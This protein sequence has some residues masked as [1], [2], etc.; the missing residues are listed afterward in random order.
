MRIPAIL[1]LLVVWILN[2]PVL[3][4]TISIGVTEFALGE[5]AFPSASECL[6][7]TGCGSRDNV[8]VDNRHP[9][10]SPVSAARALIGH[11][12]D[13]VALDLDA[14]DRI[15][16]VFPV[17]I[18]NQ[19]GPDVYTGQALF[20]GAVDGLGDPQGINDVGIRFGTLSTWHTLVL[21]DFTQDDTIGTV[22]VTYQ[23]PELKQDAYTQLRFIALD[24]S[25]FGLK[26]GDQIH[27]VTIRGSI[28]QGGSGLD[29]IVVGNLNESTVKKGR[30]L[31]R[32]IHQSEEKDDSDLAMFEYDSI[33]SD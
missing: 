4:G 10:K 7:P 12:M 8:L 14:A 22:Y 17:P 33:H 6:D 1:F 28:N 11:R 3:A 13:L 30:Y 19:A 26:A 27:E 16:L 20:V 24:L 5:D 15:R 9:L 21:S 2:T 23:D 29:V 25:D 31:P 18:E 32:D